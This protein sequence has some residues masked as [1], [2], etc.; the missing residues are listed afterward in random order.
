MTPYE[1]GYYGVMEKLGMTKLAQITREDIARGVA[2]QRLREDITPE[3]VEAAGQEAYDVTYEGGK[4]APWIG[5]GVGAG[6][7]LLLG[8]LAGG[9]EGA[10]IGAGLGGLAG[11]GL[12][13]LGR[14]GAARG[15]QSFAET[16]GET[17]RQGR[18]PYEIDEDELSRLIRAY[19]QETQPDLVGDFSRED[20]MAEMDRQQKRQALEQG[21]A[22]ALTGYAMSGD[23]WDEL[24]GTVAGAGGGVLSGLGEGRRMAGQRADLR[25]RGYGHAADI[26]EH[27]NLEY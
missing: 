16:A 5:G 4:R 14:W 20:Y 13:Q 9:P 12:G 2:G 3:D 17:A 10:A 23:G 19:T 26:L 27:R 15:E 8:G 24:K 1:Q 7:G 6:T 25:E 18:I 22:G 11:A 21:L